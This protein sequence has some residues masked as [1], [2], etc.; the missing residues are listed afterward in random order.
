MI[1]LF[2]VAVALVMALGLVMVNTIGS[3]DAQPVGV[4]MPA[5]PAAEV[6]AET[7]APVP[8]TTRTV[9]AYRPA[10]K[11]K[12]KLP[13]AV[14]N[15]AAE[16]VVAASSVAADDHPHTVTTVINTETGAV[17]TFDRRD[18]LP[19]LA[20]NTHGRAGIYYGIKN[21]VQTVRLQVEQELVQVKAVHFGVIGA[22]DQ[23]LGVPIGTDYY[24]GVGAWVNW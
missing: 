4:Q 16:Q 18:P 20:I 2:S 14:V 11:A 15:D 23:A 7:Q 10:I 17:Q 3:R 21:G 6:K 19:W 9:K 12:L 5:A 22:V 1:A 24:A 13:A 8:I